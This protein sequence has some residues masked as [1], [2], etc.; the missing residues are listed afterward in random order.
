MHEREPEVP[1]SNGGGGDTGNDMKTIPLALAA[2]LAGAGAGMAASAVN[3]DAETRTLLVTEGG[4]QT[5]LVI[6]AGQTVEFCTSGCFVTLPNGDREALTGVVT[7]EI[8]GGQGR[9]R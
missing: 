5:E 4:S 2:L 1:S 3:L 7:I 6:A 9:V 8:S